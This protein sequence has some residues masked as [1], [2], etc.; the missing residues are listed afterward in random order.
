FR[1]GRHDIR[2]TREAA[3]ALR[4]LAGQAAF[5]LFGVGL[6]GSGLL[7]IPILAGSASFAIAELMGWRS[8]LNERFGRARRFYLV[9]GTAVALGML[10]DLVGA[11]PIRM[12]FYSALVNGL[13]APPLLVIIMLVANNRHVI[14][15]RVNTLALNVLGWLVTALMTAASIAML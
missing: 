9:C 4:P 15:S 7:A 14:G 3:E 5:V 13:A 2:T 8:G 10:F 1:A 11:S 12:L 6:I